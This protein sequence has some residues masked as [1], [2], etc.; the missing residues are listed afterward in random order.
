MFRGDLTTGVE[1]NKSFAQKLKSY[2]ADITQVVNAYYKE[3][4]SVVPEEGQQPLTTPMEVE[5]ENPTVDNMVVEEDPFQVDQKNFYGGCRRGT[6]NFFKRN[7]SRQFSQ[8]N[9]QQQL[10][11]TERIRGK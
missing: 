11:S 9:H 7:Y 2:T 6:P 8:T 10:A 4:K 1:I 5:E 3:L